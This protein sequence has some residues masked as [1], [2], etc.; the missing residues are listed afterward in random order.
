[1]KHQHHQ[2]ENTVR[3]TIDFP[4][5]QHAYLKMLAAEK[6]ISM[7]QYVIESLCQNVEQ[8]AKHIDLSENKF[9]KTLNKVIKENDDVL[10]R[11]VANK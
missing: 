7:R 8:E 4:A 6:G 9:K 1:M 11:L 2:K 10:R 5:E 3:L